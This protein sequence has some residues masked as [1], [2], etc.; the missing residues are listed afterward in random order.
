MFAI[1]TLHIYYI[2]SYCVRFVLK[3]K[4][5][6]TAPRT[7]RFTYICYTPKHGAYISQSIK[8]FFLCSTFSN[9]R[10]LHLVLFIN[11][12]LYH[13]NSENLNC[14][15]THFPCN[16][17]YPYT[18]AHTKDTQV[19]IFVSGITRFDSREFSTFFIWHKVSEFSVFYRFVGRVRLR[20]L[21]KIAQTL[22]QSRKWFRY[23]QTK[24]CKLY[25]QSR[26]VIE[27]T[28][29]SFC[30]FLL[31]ARKH[32]HTTSSRKGIASTENLF[33]VSGFS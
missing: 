17:L 7:I 12:K 16:I 4:H 10:W 1:H 6:Q 30:D 15:Y 23:T 14:M 9:F 3:S 8:C 11:K 22:V 31:M 18:H 29:F 33:F 28:S 2:Y 19:Y 21:G 26:S 13:E 32:V 27:K 24:L 20:I 5:T 25:T